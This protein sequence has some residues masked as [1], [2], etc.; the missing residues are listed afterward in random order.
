V[1]LKP[2]FLIFLV[3]TFIGLLNFSIV[4]TSWLAED[5]TRSAKYPF[6]WEMTGVYTFLLLL[7][8]LYLLFSR[9]PI[10][11]LVRVPLYVAAFLAFAVS[12]T[13]LMW[14][15]REL[16]YAILGWGTYNYGTMRYRFFMEG[17][18]Q[19]IVYVSLYALVR[20][21]AYQRVNRERDAQLTEARLAALKMQLQ[22][23]F[24]FNALNTIASHVRDDPEAAAMIEHLSSFLRATLR[25]SAAQ[26]VPLREEIAFLD[27]YLAIMKARFEERLQVDVSLPA[28]VREILV[29]HLLLQPVVENSITHSLKDHARR[30]EIRIAATHEGDRLR[31]IIEDNGPG[32]LEDAAGS[33]KAVSGNGI[34][35][36]NTQARL[37]HLYGDRQSLTLANRAEGGLRLTIELPWRTA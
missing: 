32:I 13:L 33:G 31:L 26:E 14:G 34:G 20:F 10:D 18:K 24:L 5:N 8:F 19:L 17:Q 23:H 1:R 2:A 22:P 6:V 37:R 11:R 7:P 30:A 21:L 3:V 35:L 12:H 15:S 25:S 29:P 28:G 4:E 16:L 9:Y 36:A 27:S